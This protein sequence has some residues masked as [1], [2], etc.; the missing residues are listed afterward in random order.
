MP[1]ADERNLRVRRR[2]SQQVKVADTPG[3][4]GMVGGCAVSA[5]R[6][7]VVSDS[8]GVEQACYEVLLAFLTGTG[9]LSSHLAPQGDARMLACGREGGG[10][11]VVQQRS[12]VM[13]GIW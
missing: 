13:A 10:G 7:H 9:E 12:A 1:Y 3:P 8:P 11:A 6:A 5:W 2:N 4:K